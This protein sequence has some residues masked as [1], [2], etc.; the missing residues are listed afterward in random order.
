MLDQQPLSPPALDTGNE[1]SRSPHTTGDTQ[2]ADDENLP[3]PLE[4]FPTDRANFAENIQDAN[5]RRY[6]LKM[7][8]CRPKGPF[9]TDNDNQCFSKSYYTSTTKIGIKLPRSWMCYS[10]KLDCCYCEPCWLF[11][12]R[13]APYYNNAWVNGI[14]DWKHLST[15]IEKH[16]STQIHLGACIVY[17]Q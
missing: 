2:T 1:S 10:P 16:E 7:G 8:P 11:A 9:P 4:G 14:K 12:N 15:K 17:E 5:I 3:A 6:I 13:S